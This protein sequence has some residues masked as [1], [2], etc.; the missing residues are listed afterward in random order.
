MADSE[1]TTHFVAISSV[2]VTRTLFNS[3]SII[4]KISRMV[5]SESVV[6]FAPNVVVIK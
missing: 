2:F 1:T 3:I 6:R 4:I 5:V